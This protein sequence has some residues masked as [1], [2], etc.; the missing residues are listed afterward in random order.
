MT[1]IKKYAVGFGMTGQKLEESVNCLIKE[2]Y[3]PIGGIAAVVE[4]GEKKMY[5]AMV[6]L[7]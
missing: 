3:E 5:Q 4:E 2:G 7:K 6:K 1:N